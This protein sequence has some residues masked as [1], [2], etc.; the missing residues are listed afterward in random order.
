MADTMSLNRWETIKKS[1]QFSNNDD[2]S[3]ENEDSLFKVRALVSHLTAKL[4]QIPMA[5][6][7]A[8]DEQMV[9]FKG[10]NKLKQYLPK[11][12]KKWAYKIFI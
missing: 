7:L 9:P 4:K 11:K 3:E 12:T 10:K 1:L 5:E 8:V 2:R 6:K